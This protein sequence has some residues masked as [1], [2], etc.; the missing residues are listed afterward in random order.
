[1]GAPGRLRDSGRLLGPS[2]NAVDRRHSAW[3]GQ[4]IKDRSKTSYELRRYA[5][6]VVYHA[7]WDILK[8]R[9]FLRRTSVETTQQ[10]YVSLLWITNFVLPPIRLNRPQLAVALT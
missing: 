6:S 8:V 9:D 10:W 4:W 7:T 3:I 2:A 1:M 5:G